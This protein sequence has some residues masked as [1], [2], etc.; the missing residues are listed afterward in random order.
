MK[1]PKLE[2][3]TL[4]QKIGQTACFRHQYLHRIKDYKEYFSNNQV[5]FLWPMRHDTEYY[6]EFQE[7]KGNPELLGLKD[8]MFI[9]VVNEMSKN[10]LIPVM[11]VVDASQGMTKGIFDKHG[12]LTTVLGIG[13][14]NTPE[15]AYKY[16]NLLGKDL[17]SV[18]FRW[19]W[20]P[21]ADNPGKYLDTRCFGCNV[22]DNCQM[23]SSFVQGL[24]D[25]G[26]AGSAKH[27]PGSDPL[28]YRDSH[29]CTASYTLSLEEWEKTQGKEFKSCIDAGVASIMVG[30]HTFRAVDDSTV[31]GVLRPAALSKKIVTGLL[32]EKMGFDGVVISDDVTMKGF[33]AV[34]APK[35]L[36]VEMLNA[37]VDVL[38]GPVD[39]DYVDIVEQAVLN[40]EIPE[41]RIDDACSRILKMK[42]KFLSVQPVPY[43]TEET[44]D[45]IKK[46]M[47]EFCSE[48]AKKGLTLTANHLNLIPIKEKEVRNVKIF[49]IGYSDQ[50]FENL[51][52]M[53]D[54]FEKHGA[55]CTLKKGIDASDPATLKD[56]DLV[57]YATY[58]GMHAPAGGQFFYG[59][60]CRMMYNVMTENVE[61]SVAVSFGCTDVYFNYFTAAPAYVNCYSTTPEIIRGFVKGLYG[62]LEFNSYNPCP[63]NPIT[64]T[65]E[66]Y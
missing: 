42:E 25:A 39:L 8:N 59:D 33:M 53:V 28:E 5:G 58:I 14:T 4:R 51:Q 36:Y 46:E 65:N 23:L 24:Q 22:E 63:L 54:E 6:K 10:M 15:Y 7:K 66:V 17:S 50:C 48:V 56:C 64:R 40:G 16:A 31:N 2:D 19:L 52:Y 44:R 27:F 47:S 49:Y 29:F 21:V 30:C 12:E 43:L 62:E 20:S 37:G 38:L 11:P 61:R 45:G 41:S 18:G 34:F 1:L 57:V 32:K 60:E 26:V 13:A 55:T 3:M 9:D 35:R